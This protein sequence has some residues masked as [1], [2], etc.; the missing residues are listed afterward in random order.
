[1]CT[2]VEELY[3]CYDYFLRLSGFF[4]LFGKVLL[5]TFK[6]PLFEFSTIVEIAIK[7]K[8][9]NYFLYSEKRDYNG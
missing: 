6:F 8:Q 4:D 2:L 3:K 5:I 1:M 7:I 9:F